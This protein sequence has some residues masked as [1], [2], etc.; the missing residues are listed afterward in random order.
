MSYLKKIWRIYSDHEDDVVE[1][2]DDPDALGL[3]EMKVVINKRTNGER[4]FSFMMTTKMVREVARSILEAAE[5]IDKRE[6]E[7]WAED[8][9]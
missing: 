8:N 1:V 4:N 6:A 5:W 2:S 9:G 7:R 3:I